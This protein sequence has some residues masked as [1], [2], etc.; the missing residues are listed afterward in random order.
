MADDS[1]TQEGLFSGIIDAVKQGFMNNSDSVAGAIG[2]SAYTQASELMDLH[3]GM[4]NVFGKNND[5]FRNMYAGVSEMQTNFY[6]MAADSGAA[7]NTIFKNQGELIGEYQGIISSNLLQIHATTETVTAKEMADLTLYGRALDFSSTQ[8]QKFLERQFALTGEV[9]NDLL[10]QTLA[11]ANAIEEETGI[12]SKIIAE[13]VS[14]MMTDIRTFGNMTVEEMSEAAAAIAKV[15]LEVND[16]AG[17]VKKFSTFEGAADSVSKLTQVFGVQMDTMKYMTASFESPQDMLAMIQEDFEAAGVNMADM[18]MAQKRLLAD[19]T[20]MSISAVESL[21]GEAGSGLSS[22]A[23]DVSGATAGVGETEIAS[24]LA[25]A[26]D[27]IARL[28]QMGSSVEDGMRKLAARTNRAI[29]SVFSEGV[30]TLAD[31]ATELLG[32]VPRIANLTTR[33]GKDQLEQSLGVTVIYEQVRGTI[34]AVNETVVDGLNN[35]QQAVD[36]KEGFLP[37]LMAFVS[38]MLPTDAGTPAPTFDFEDPP[39]SDGSTRGTAYLESSENANL[40]DIEGG[41]TGDIIIADDIDVTQLGTIL[42]T[43]SVETNNAITD[44]QEAHLATAIESIIEAQRENRE[45]IQ[46]D[47]KNSDGSLEYSTDGGNEWHSLRTPG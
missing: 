14:G 25:N 29:G 18:D 37:T 10:Q 44:R 17:L 27:D 3:V 6:G 35:G 43:L 33:A 42:S 21:L 46:I 7:L 36:N 4:V 19:T 31:E 32:N 8:T 15:G 22:F 41:G 11:Y 24:S 2:A 13:N 12:S 9:S 45:A 47:L 16:V 40:G 28:N 20:G 38:R 26:G 30:R 1:T 39:T 5:T 34:A 23:A